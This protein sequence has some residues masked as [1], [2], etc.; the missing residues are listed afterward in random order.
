M[1]TYE[2]RGEKAKPWMYEGKRL[3]TAVQCP[4]C[5]AY[6]EVELI[7]GVNY[8]VENP[9]ECPSCGEKFHVWAGVYYNKYEGTIEKVRISVH[10]WDG[11]PDGW[12]VGGPIDMEPLYYRGGDPRGGGYYSGDPKVGARG[13]VHKVGPR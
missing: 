12:P 9:I 1:P 2:L 7:A 10:E 5:G 11:Y 13:P 3:I 8:S 4:E 6:Y